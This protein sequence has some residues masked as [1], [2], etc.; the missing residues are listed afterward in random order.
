MIFVRD[1]E[2]RSLVTNYASEE[3]GTPATPAATVA[4]A[5]ALLVGTPR[6]CCILVT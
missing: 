3:G 2:S 1:V 4:A 6:S 5:V